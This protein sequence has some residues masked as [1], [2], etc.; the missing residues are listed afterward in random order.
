MKE[1]FD[2]DENG[3]QEY[4]ENKFTCS[5]YMCSDIISNIL[6]YAYE[7]FDC[8]ADRMKCFITSLLPDIEEEEIEKFIEF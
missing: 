2:F 4:I 6:N 3:L 1:Y 7:T 8:D 5:A